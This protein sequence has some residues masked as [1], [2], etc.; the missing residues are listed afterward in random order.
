M[1]NLQELLL[2]VSKHFGYQVGVKV[3]QEIENVLNVEK[4]DFGKLQ[5]A[6]KTIQGLLDADPS[7]PEFDVG[8]NIVTQLIDHAN[9]IKTLQDQVK[10]LEDKVTES[11]DDVKKQLEQEISDLKATLENEINQVKT[12]LTDAINKAKQEAIDTAT[13]QA[14]EYTDNAIQAQIDAVDV[15]KL[16]DAFARAIDCG[17]AGKTQEECA[18]KC[19]SGSG[20]ATG[21]ATGSANASAS[22]SSSSTGSASGSATGSASGSAGANGEDDGAVV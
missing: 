5:D 15:C 3:K 20:S 14:K 9:K 2:L 18:S 7:T 12:D 21:S 17:L 19:N 6:I 13:A 11:T 10:A 22:N 8:Q 1:Q 4:I 16:A